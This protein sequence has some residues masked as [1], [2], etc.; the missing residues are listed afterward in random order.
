MGGV[1]RPTQ[2]FTQARYTKRRFVFSPKIP[3]VYSYIHLIFFFEKL[4]ILH[5]GHYNIKSVRRERER[6]RE[7]ERDRGGE[8]EIDLF[9]KLI[10][11]V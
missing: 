8:R 2:E 6:E 4:I 5:L 9:S 1:S 3:L 7:R 10:L 11:S